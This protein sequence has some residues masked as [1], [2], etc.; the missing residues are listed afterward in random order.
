VD[1]DGDRHVFVING[2]EPIATSADGELPQKL[3]GV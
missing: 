1:G 2:G 3:S